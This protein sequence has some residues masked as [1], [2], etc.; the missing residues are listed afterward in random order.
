MDS[1]S[2]LVKRFHILKNKNLW[3]DA[4]EVIKPHKHNKKAMSIYTEIFFLKLPPFSQPTSLPKE[5]VG[6]IL[7]DLAMP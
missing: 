3:D 6:I 5:T 2:A 4:A 1:N 7:A